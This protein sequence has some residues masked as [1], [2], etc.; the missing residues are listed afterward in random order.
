LC[1]PHVEQIAKLEYGGTLELEDALQKSADEGDHQRFY[2][3]FSAIDKGKVNSLTQTLAR[4]P[5]KWV[6]ELLEFLLERCG[7]LHAA[8][9]FIDAQG[10]GKVNRHDWECALMALGYVSDDPG[11]FFRAS[12][13]DVSGDL[14]YDE[15]ADGMLP[16]YQAVFTKKQQN[17]LTSSADSLATTS[18]PATNSPENGRR[19]GVSSS[20]RPS[21]VR[22]T[23][24]G[25][26]KP[27]RASDSRRCSGGSP[28]HQAN[29]SPGSQGFQ[30][31]AMTR[32][33]AHLLEKT[34]A[35]G[36]AFKLVDSLLGQGFRKNLEAAKE[37][38]R[39]ME[40]VLRSHNAQAFAAESFSRDSF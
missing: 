4:D 14:T 35:L 27:R 2:M 30:E 22:S 26:R 29:A 38:E 21:L 32:R 40:E 33:E 7:S 18:P 5:A 25:T 31:K 20:C 6:V 36:D 16:Y 15:V 8:F 24:S 39:Y 1:D 3:L 10:R 17:G 23:T 9:S 12:D 19:P 13:K 11:R 34:K 28:K 37:K